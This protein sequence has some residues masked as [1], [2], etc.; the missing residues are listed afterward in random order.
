M[1]KRSTIYSLLLATISTLAQAQTYPV[2]PVRVINPSGAGS[3]TDQ[4]FRIIAGPMQTQ[5]GQPLVVDQRAG[6]GGTLGQTL[7]AKSTTDGYTIG[8]HAG[9]FVQGPAVVKNLAYDPA[10]DFVA[11]GLIADV[12]TVLLVHPSLPVRSVKELIALAR[13]R[14]GELNSGNSGPGGNSHLANLLFNDLAKVDVMP[15]AHKSSALAAIAL[16]GGHIHLTFASAPGVMDYVRSGRLRLLAQGSAKRA[17]TLPDTPTMQEAGVAGYLMQSMFGALAPA[18]FAR[19]MAER[20]NAALIKTLQEPAVRKML[21][22][23][24]AEPVGSSMETHDT[25]IKTE[26]SRWLKIAKQAGI[27]PQ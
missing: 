16:L 8:L 9:G 6:A 15:V 4:I 10:R 23:L 1:L 26:V 21:T 27:E 11:L 20:L 2:K 12:P 5:L 22:E 24:G 18:G 14:P 17:S 3:T 7:I 19:P 25:F 13:S